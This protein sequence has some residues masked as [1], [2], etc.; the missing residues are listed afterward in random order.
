MATILV[1][2]LLAL[3][4]DNATNIVAVDAQLVYIGPE[5]GPFAAAVN[6]FEKVR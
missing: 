1:P 5:E 6:Y 3:T 2:F 4:N